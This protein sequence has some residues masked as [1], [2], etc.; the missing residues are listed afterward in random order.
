M[1]DKKNFQQ[2]KL[3]KYSTK[4]KCHCQHKEWSDQVK[5]LEIG[6]KESKFLDAVSALD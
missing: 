5:D 1:T 2:A 4:A 6:F 3:S